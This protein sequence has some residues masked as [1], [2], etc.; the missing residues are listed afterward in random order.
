MSDSVLQ[1]AKRELHDFLRSRP[2]WMGC[3]AA[4]CLLG[5][6]GPFGTGEVMRL[7]PRLV[8]WVL[9]A[10]LSFPT[11]SIVSALVRD[12]TAR[13]A[14]PAWIA[15]AVSSLLAGIVILAE[16]VALNAL[17]FGRLP[18]A[19][20][21]LVLAANVLAASAVVTVTASLIARDMTRRAG[22]EAATPRL[23]DRLPIERR[24]ALVSLSAVDHYVEVTTTKGT[25]LLLM[26]LTD[27]I[28]EA[29]PVEG[30][31]IHRSHWVASD[32]VR[33]V[34]RDGGRAQVRLSDDRMLPVSRGNVASL[35]K[36]G[37]MAD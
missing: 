29:H 32:H 10:S 27:A 4:G 3:V 19:Q 25:E 14:L 2:I 31:Q 1:L 18:Q 26:R 24:G 6:A 33:G 28:A 16:V 30:L 21:L 15:I 5:I 34:S 20:P 23:L 35:R 11:G 17:I 37:L 7:L 9:L 12:R 22:T 8:Y 36:A 13:S